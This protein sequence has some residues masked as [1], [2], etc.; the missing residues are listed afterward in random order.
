[1]AH[2]IEIINGEASMFYYG[3][4]PWHGLGTDLKKPATSSE[5]IKA[6]K[7]DWVVEKRQL[8]L[9]NNQPVKNKFATVRTDRPENVLGIVGST[10]TPLQNT[11]AFKFFDSIVIDNQ[12]MYHTAGSLLEGKVV[13]ILAKLPGEIKITGEDITKK[14]LLLSNSHDGSSAVQ[15]KFTPIRV[16]CNNTLTMA[17]G[18]QQ[19]LSVYHQRDIKARLNDVPKLLNIINSRYTEIDATL[20]ELVKIQMT[21]ITLEKYL[22][23]VFPD[24]KRKKEE[25]LYEYELSRA[26]T[27]REWSKFFFEN[28]VGNKLPGVSGSLWATLNGITE[29]ID[30]KVTKQS[31]DRKLNTIWFGDGAAVKAKAYKLAVGMVSV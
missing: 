8:F 9:D 6:A 25:K 29:L 24:P 17:F 14:Y 18:D 27:N 13:W 2:N 20:K 15:I 7:L 28:G 26:K 1:M 12:A 23:D 5:A 21:D 10:Y 11:D 31:Q 22:L 3:K 16:V 4:T 30:H 19:F